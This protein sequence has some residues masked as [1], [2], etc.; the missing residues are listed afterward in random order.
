MSARKWTKEEERI[1]EE[2]YMLYD[3][4]IDE[5]VRRLDRSR[6]SIRN[7]VYSLGLSGMYKAESKRFSE[8][9]RWT[10]WNKIL[11]RAR[12]FA[13]LPEVPAYENPYKG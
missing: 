12:S 3:R 10:M 4:P 5:A 7:K 8:A 1:L 6:Q 11:N 2:C 9:E 13:N